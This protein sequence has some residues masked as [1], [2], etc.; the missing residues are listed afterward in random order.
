MSIPQPL[1]SHSLFRA[2]DVRGVYAANLTEH[3]VRLI[4]QAMMITGSHHPPDQN[5]I[6]I[7]I[8]CTPPTF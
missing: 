5:G 2:Y 6:K 7:V 4:G 3:S 1:I 8:I